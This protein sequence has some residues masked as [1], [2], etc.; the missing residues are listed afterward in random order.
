GK[1]TSQHERICYN[2]PAAPQKEPA[3]ARQEVSMTH[4]PAPVA[5]VNDRR[6]IF[7]W[8]TYDWANS[9]FSTTVVT[10]LAG[11]YLTALAQGQVG[12]N[13]LLWQIG[14]FSSTAESWFP[15]C[16]SLSVFLQ[17]FMLPI[18]GAIADYTQLKKR[19]M[20]VFC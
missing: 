12:Q 20:Q 14:P 17:V 19:L 4:T 16:A 3:R 8:I 15:Y 1:V 2:R 6:E 9:V 7:G 11:P 5:P 18:L 13:G 10:A